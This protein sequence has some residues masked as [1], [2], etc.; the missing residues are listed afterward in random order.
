MSKRILVVDD[1]H[2]V[3]DASARLIALCGYEVKAVYDGREAIEQSAA[4]APDMV[5]MDLGMPDLD[6]YETASRIRRQQGNANL[7]LI[8][9]TC[10]TQDQEIKRA[11][12]S[13]FNLH[14]A[15]PLSLTALYG[16]LGMLH[17][18]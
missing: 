3:A 2:Y 10:W 16:L 13:G 18:R 8:A 15:K 6:G 12:E 7:L 9:V 17:Q 5:L 4:F 14:V 11:Y 1:S